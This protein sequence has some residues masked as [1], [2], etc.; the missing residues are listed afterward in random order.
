VRWIEKGKPGED[1]LTI[2]N[3]NIPLIKDSISYSA[4]IEIDP[5]MDDSGN[6]T[7]LENGRFGP[8]EPLW[9]Y[10]AK[11]TIS[12]YGSFVSGAERLENGN[13]IINEGPKGRFFEVTPDGEIVWE[14]LNPYRG[15]IRETNGD[16]I[17]PLPMAY[18]QFRA[19]FIP[20]DHPALQGRDL[21]PLEPQP[22]YF[23]LPPKKED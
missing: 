11:D 15:T 7:R 22:E 13:T 8:E 17:N 5:P 4:V 19:N 9:Q 3:N 1:H 21:K 18:M 10:L 12:F 14:Y 23:K 16:T 20:A 6:Y 2:Y